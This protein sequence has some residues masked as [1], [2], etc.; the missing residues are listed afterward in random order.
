MSMCLAYRL[1][2]THVH[3]TFS[4]LNR[5]KGLY[6]IFSFNC[7]LLT[8]FHTISLDIIHGY[9]CFQ[10]RSWYNSLADPRAEIPPGSP[11]T[12]G[13]HAVLAQRFV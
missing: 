6:Y 13:V 2:V 7:N 12:Y 1:L 5:I 10:L 3:K 8:I 4:I 11:L 9:L